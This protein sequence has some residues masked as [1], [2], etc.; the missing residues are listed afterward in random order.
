MKL[1]N[2][3]EK[4]KLDQ[5]KKIRA[6]YYKSDCYEANVLRRV[7]WHWTMLHTGLNVVFSL[8]RVSFFFT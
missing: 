3:Y 8:T 6:E 5:I 2:K 7:N 4:T 1:F